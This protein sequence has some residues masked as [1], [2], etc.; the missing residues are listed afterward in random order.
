MQCS[1]GLWKQTI[2]ADG[3][4]RLGGTGSW[5]HG[6]ICENTAPY[7]VVRHSD[8]AV[9]DVDFG[10]SGFGCPDDTQHAAAHV[11]SSTRN[12]GHAELA[13]PGAEYAGA[14]VA[15]AVARNV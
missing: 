7:F 2:S 4:L 3:L 10:S 1:D 12:L 9:R 6:G 8:H 13:S 5:P 15:D 14:I 11:A